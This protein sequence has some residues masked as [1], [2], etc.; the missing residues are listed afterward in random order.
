MNI[1]NLIKCSTHQD[2]ETMFQPGWLKVNVIEDLNH[3][4]S[5]P[6]K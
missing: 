4:S 5:E 6:L 2:A 1:M 3:V